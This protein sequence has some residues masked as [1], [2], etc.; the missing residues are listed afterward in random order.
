MSMRKLF[1]MLTAGATLIGLSV[2]QTVLL[3]HWE[4]FHEERERQ[5]R[6]K[7]EVLRLE[8]LVTDVD[9]GFRGY[10]LMKQGV[11]LGPMIA[12]EG[13]IPGVVEGLSLMTEE[14]PD[15]QGLVGV[16]KTRVTE[17]LDV[18]RR[19]TLELEHG[20]EQEVLA[21]IRGGE[22]LALANTIALVIQDLNR[23][24]NQP[25]EERNREAAKKMDVVRWSLTI[26]SIGGVVCGIGIGRA[27]CRS[28]QTAARSGEMANPHDRASQSQLPRP[29]D[30]I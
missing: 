2:I 5:A 9:N 22:D 23:K 14:R 3:E 24:L 21:Y 8:R 26:V 30:V 25:E 18:K 28:G 10:V 13:T 20:S 6:I 17:L 11:F 16:L 4:A 1:W 12:A 19:L 15:L 29:S 27:T 7:H